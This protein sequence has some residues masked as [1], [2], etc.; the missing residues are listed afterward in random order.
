MRKI[1]SLSM[2]FAVIGICILAVA[3]LFCMSFRN[4]APIMIS[5]PD[6][7]QECSETLMKA[8]STGDYDTASDCLSG[9]PDLGLDREPEDEG[10]QL[11]WDAFAD[12]FQYEFTGECYATPSG[13]AQSVMIT[14]LDLTKIS[15]KLPQR[16]DDL[17][18][19]KL[20]NTTTMTE[21]YDSKGE[22]RQDLI[23]QLLLQAISEILEEDAATITRGVSLNLVY[24]NNRWWVSLDP[25]LLQAI[26]GGVAG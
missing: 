22:F 13:L 17:M 3:A 25:A 24:E 1:Q 21:I 6:A 2:I 8:L 19:E 4:A 5:V 15:S 7:A 11:I 18:A 10:S 12:S 9:Q 23:Q 20:A 16:M 26:S 14:T